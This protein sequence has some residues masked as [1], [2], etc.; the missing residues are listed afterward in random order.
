MVMTGKERIHAVLKGEEVDRIPFAIN[1]WQWFYANQYWGNLTGELNKLSTP[2]E[3]LKYLGADI[4]TRWDGQIKGRSGLG[5]YVKFPNCEYTIS[6]SGEKPPNPL[7]T[8][9]N[10][11]TEGTKIHRKLE[12]PHG[13]LTQ[14][15]RF[16]KRPVPISRKII[17]LRI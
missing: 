5:D 6:F 15:W 16:P 1:A 3:F 17:G 8:A 11:Y 12:T 10:T 7:V 14:T 13:A 4:L 9:F 2:I